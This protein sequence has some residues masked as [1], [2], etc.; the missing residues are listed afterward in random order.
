MIQDQEI[1]SG[2]LWLLLE[3]SQ[4]MVVKRRGGFMH[5]HIAE[6]N[7]DFEW[8]WHHRR[9]ELIALGID[10]APVNDGTRLVIWWLEAPQAKDQAAELIKASS[11]TDADIQVSVPE[12]LVLRGYQKACVAFA[13]GKRALLNGDDVGL[14]K[15]VETVAIINDHPE[16]KTGLIICPSVAKINWLRELRRWLTRPISMWIADASMFPNREL[17]I[18]NFELLGKFEKQMERDWDFIVIDEIHRIKNPKSLAHKRCMNLQKYARNRIGLSGTPIVNEA[19]DL[20]PI[21]SWLDPIIYDNP[22]RFKHHYSETR[23]LHNH[24]R[25][26]IMVRR[27]KKEVLTELPPLIHRIIEFDCPDESMAREEQEAWGPKAAKIQNMEEKVANAERLKDDRAYRRAL[28]EL[29]DV[30]KVAFSEMS[31]FR[32]R[33]AEAKFPLCMEFLRAAMEESD[34]IGVFAHHRHILEAAHKE[35]PKSVLLYGG[36]HD[37]DKQLS[38]DRFQNDPAVPVFFGSIEATGEAITL[39]ASSRVLF[40]ELDWR[41]SKMTQVAGRFHRMGQRDSVLCDY[42]VLKNSCDAK[43]ARRLVMKAELTEDILDR[44]LK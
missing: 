30:W 41:P 4:P 23:R 35:T 19:E 42:L 17:V 29:D 15:S 3:W 37:N 33:T 7:A 20:F 1:T 6:P 8:L 2:Y 25:T 14:G 11:A 22:V 12:G 24:L 26:H 16:W 34:K 27:L 36:M 38:I 44:G 32:K 5:R 9:G 13:R 21:L 43:L 31:A 39:T 40:F 10:R 28:E 18:I